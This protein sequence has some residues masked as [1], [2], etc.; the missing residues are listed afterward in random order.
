VSWR[1]SRDGDTPVT[2]ALSIADGELEA[3]ITPLLGWDMTIVIGFTER[4]T[5]GQTYNSA[6]VISDSS[7]S[8]IYRKTYP[9]LRPACPAFACRSSITAAWPSA[10]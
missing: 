10:C 2:V 1:T 7:M 6:V 5:G 9:A 4:G 3:A 8:G